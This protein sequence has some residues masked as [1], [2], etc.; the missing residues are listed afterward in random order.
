VWNRTADKAESL[1][2]VAAVAADPAA[3]AKGA[4]IVLTM[5][6]DGDTVA[7]VVDDDVLGALGSGGLWLQM[8]TV[9]ATAS[10]TFAERADAAGVAFVD[11]PVLGTREPAERAALVVLASGDAALADRCA[12]V[13][14]AVGTRTLWVGEAGMGSRLKLVVNAWILGLVVALAEAVGLAEAL[15][16]DPARFLEA[17]DGSAVGPAYAQTKGAA[18]MARDFPASF[19][20][21]LAL[22]DVRLVL[23]AARDG[24]LRPRLA[25]A[26]EEAFAAAVADG[27][28]DED[29]A[30]VI[31]AVT[32][33]KG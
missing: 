23:A 24:E 7:A 11:A 16:L 31:H 21:R 14:D 26:V 2:D 6:A 33:S 15:D 10:D 19:P 22:K 30:A 9:G 32:G 27:H 3:A 29:M 5:L 25:A 4:D 28:A 18:M 20:A 1:A 12:P 8:S 17:I 13:F